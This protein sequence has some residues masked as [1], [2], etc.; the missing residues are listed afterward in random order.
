[1]LAGLS[2]KKTAADSFMECVV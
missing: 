2:V 1:M